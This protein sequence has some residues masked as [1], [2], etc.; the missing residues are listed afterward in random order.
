VRL[1]HIFAG[2]AVLALLA[3]AA[4]QADAGTRLN[5]SKFPFIFDDGYDNDEFYYEDPPPRRRALRRK[6]RQRQREEERYFS[7]DEVEPEQYG[8]YEPDLQDDV[9]D[10][11]P[12]RRLDKVRKA[13]KS[14]EDPAP[15]KAAQ[16][17]KRAAIADPPVK[18]KPK[19]KPKPAAKPAEPEADTALQET[20]TVL[21]AE[22]LPSLAGA[23]SCAQAT[24]IVTGYGFGEV[25]PTS[26][27]GEVYAFRASRAGKTYE[28]KLAAD[29]GELTEVAK[30]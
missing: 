11:P 6:L 7:R 27:K 20:G 9:I 5:F 8:I 19:P 16:K 30:Q 22:K 4:P 3:V 23:V 26:C 2:S 13:R 29:S 15:P 25:K 1:L 12:R 21:P 24:D 28:I 10:I 14:G 17:K 18:P